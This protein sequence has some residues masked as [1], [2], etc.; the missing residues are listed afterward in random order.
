MSDPDVGAEDGWNRFYVKSSGALQRDLSVYR[1]ESF[2][3]QVFTV[4]GDKH[5]AQIVDAGGTVVMT[6]VAKGILAKIEYMRSDGTLAGKL[7][8]NSIFSKKRLEFT[9]ADGT[10]WA[11]IQSGALK[12]IY[13]VLEND[14]PIA[15]LDLTDL[16]LKKQYPVDIAQSVDLPLALGLVWAINFTYLQTVAAGGRACCYLDGSSLGCNRAT[17]NAAVAA[18]RGET[19]MCPTVP[20]MPRKGASD[21]SSDREEKPEWNQ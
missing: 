13:S 4:V 14:V 3:D 2:E 19:I 8:T 1:D 16:A 7:T 20:P 17:V 11:V 12:K 10:E 9:L 15:K 21:S 6:A 18:F 5:S